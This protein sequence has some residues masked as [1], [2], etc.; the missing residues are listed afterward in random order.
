MRRLRDYLLPNTLTGVARV[1]DVGGSFDRP[2]A[3]I[4]K[5]H[6]KS[7]TS[8]RTSDLSAY[9]RARDAGRTIIVRVRGATKDEPSPKR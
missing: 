5:A 7:I 1:L 3:L 9:K 2:G 8:V 4:V 6:K